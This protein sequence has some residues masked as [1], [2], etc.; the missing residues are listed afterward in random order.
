MSKKSMRNGCMLGKQPAKERIV[1]IS[2]EEE[3]W[4]I[5][6]IRNMNTQWLKIKIRKWLFDEEYFMGADYGYHESA[7]IIIKRN[8]KTGTME[9]I[10][11]NTKR[12]DYEKEFEMRIRDLAKKY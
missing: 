5:T 9:V 10:A 7:I 4:Q 1:T 8:R 6:I 2:H 3:K 12:N 11:E